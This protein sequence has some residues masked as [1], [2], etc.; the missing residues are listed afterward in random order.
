METLE[1]KTETEPGS[2][3]ESAAGGSDAASVG[4]AAAIAA[5]HGA[6]GAGVGNSTSGNP[7]RPKNRGG[8]P[9]IHGRYSRANGSDGKNP[10]GEIP[11][12]AEVKTDEG[13]G[14]AA[15]A[16]GLSSVLGLVVKSALDGV[17][18]GVCDKLRRLGS[19]AGLTTGE[20]SDCVERA[21]LGEI[22]KQAVVDLA[23]AI[24]AE[25]GLDPKVSPTLAAAAVLS[26]WGVGA[27]LSLKSLAETAA[28]RLKILKESKGGQP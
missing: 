9:P 5:K 8:R 23:P 19:S 24:A 28:E 4:L 22:R 27:Y 20:I 25:W 17:E 10:V 21:K 16:V 2:A 14:G 13:S 15:A 11:A 7:E 26:P 1:T 18:S 3:P 12:K 6:T